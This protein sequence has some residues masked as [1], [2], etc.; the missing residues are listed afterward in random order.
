[1][2]GNTGETSDQ[3]L[4]ALFA[5][6]GVPRYTDNVQQLEALYGRLGIQRHT[7]SDQTICLVPIESFS[8][9]SACLSLQELVTYSQHK[10]RGRKD[11]KALL[12]SIPPLWEKATAF[13]KRYGKFL[14]SI[15]DSN[16]LDREFNQESHVLQERCVSY[17]LM[18]EGEVAREKSQQGQ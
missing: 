7:N 12:L 17:I 10:F 3:G 9:N 5:R 1:M 13:V 11:S 2:A 4:E 16:S 15:T 18:L 6:L 14:P 8:S